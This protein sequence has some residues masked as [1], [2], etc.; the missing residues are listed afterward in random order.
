M[1]LTNNTSRFSLHLHS[2]FVGLDVFF[3]LQFLYSSPCSE[4]QWNKLLCAHF[5]FYALPVK[6]ASPSASADLYTF[7]LLATGFHRYVTWIWK[8]HLHVS[9]SVP[10]HFKA[11]QIKKLYVE[12]GAFSV[13]HASVVFRLCS[14]R[15]RDWDRP[16]GFSSCAASVRCLLTSKETKIQIKVQFILLTRKCSVKL[17]LHFIFS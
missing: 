11:L 14:F 8:Q 6:L 2:Q 3:S 9:P 13:Q 17:H 16:R 15:W 10:L 5:I 12:F 7:V 4:T 1:P